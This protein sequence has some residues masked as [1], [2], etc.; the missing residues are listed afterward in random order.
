MT[1][2]F[3]LFQGGGTPP[4]AWNEGKSK[5]LNQLKKIG[6]VYTYQNKVYN[7]FY[8]NRKEKGW[9]DFESNIDFDMDYLDI[10]KHI[11]MIFND[12]KTKYNIDKVKLVPIAWSAGGYFAMAFSKK[13]KKY[14]KLCVL[15]DSVTISP[16]SIKYR[17][18]ESKNEIKK[19][20]NFK[21]TKFDDDELEILQQKII[22]KNNKSDIM[23]LN[24]I[25]YYLWAIWVNKNLTTKL[26]VQTLSFYNINLLET[27]KNSLPDFNNS[28]KIHDVET[29]KD[30][31]KFYKNIYVINKTHALFMKK[32][33]AKDII[34]YIQL[35]I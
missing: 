14:C 3:I 18:Q 35:L 27:K 5:F 34:S 21:L 12:I 2:L 32:D 17:L 8:Y 15:L 24:N 20:K 16:K 11:T 25:V 29:L 23:K 4:S 13:Y 30:N 31:N 10:N 22:N 28:L 33:V 9:E 6:N 26:Y 1:I 7:I 19:Y